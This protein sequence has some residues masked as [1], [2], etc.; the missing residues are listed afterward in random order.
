MSSLD[1]ERIWRDLANGLDEDSKADFFRL[2]VPFSGDE[3]RLDDIG[4]V[5]ELRKSVHLQPEGLR[6]RSRIALALLVASFFFE[7]ENI[8]T[9]EGGQYLCRGFIRCRNEAQGVVQ[10]LA[11]LYGEKLEFTMETGTLGILSAADIC[12]N[13]HL[14]CK[15]VSFYVRHLDESI[16]MHLKVNVLE[17]RKLSGFPHN[18]AWFVRQ[19]HVDSPF[20]SAEHGSPGL[21]RCR[22]CDG[23]QTSPEESGCGRKRGLDEVSSPPLKSKRA[24]TALDPRGRHK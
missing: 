10:S 2:N 15:K 14:Y 13:C 24:R 3:P 7:L 18:M 4:C 1:G 9:F 20:G 17:R 5:N 8:P 12:T 22:A 21:L 6:D 16:S 19:Q 11:R 23:F